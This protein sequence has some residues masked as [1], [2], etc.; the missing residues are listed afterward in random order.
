MQLI[1][2]VI[3]SSLNYCD[4]IEFDFWSILWVILT[5][6]FTLS[7]SERTQKTRS[8][9]TA[10]AGRVKITRSPPNKL[11]NILDKDQACMGWGSILVRGSGF[12]CCPSVLPCPA[13][14]LLDSY[15]PKLLPPLQ[16]H[17]NTL[18][19]GRLCQQQYI[20]FECVVPRCCTAPTSLSTIDCSCLGHEPDFGCHLFL[21]G[22]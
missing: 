13:T 2:T 11:V 7:C 16:M 18:F 19:E 14:C 8:F 17:V 15:L 1:K 6:H 10:T 5:S 21:R 9:W 12:E 20:H 4:T 3:I 22:E